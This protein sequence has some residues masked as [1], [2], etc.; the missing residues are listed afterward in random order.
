M[1]IPASGLGF[2]SAGGLGGGDPASD[3]VVLGRE[4]L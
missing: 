3:I 2:A 1:H 4:E